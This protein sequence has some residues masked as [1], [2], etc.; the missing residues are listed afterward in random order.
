VDNKPDDPERIIANVAE[1]LAWCGPVTQH[2]G[3]QVADFSTRI[4]AYSRLGER[5]HFC[6]AVHPGSGIS[7]LADAPTFFREILEWVSIPTDK[8]RIVNAPVYARQLV[9]VPQQEQLQVGPS[10]DYLDLL[11]DNFYRKRIP[12]PRAKIYYIS[13]AGMPVHFA[14]ESFIE[15]VLGQS[16]VSVIRPESLSLNEQL[17]IL[18]GARMLLF[19]EGSALH[20]I[21]LLGRNVAEVHILNRR[22]GSSLARCSLNPRCGNV[23]YHNIGDLVH[24][25]NRVGNPC[26]EVGIAVPDITQLRNAITSTGLKIKGWSDDLFRRFVESDIS[27][28]YEREA[29]SPRANV[30][31]SMEMID[32]QLEALGRKLSPNSDR[33]SAA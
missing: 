4:A 8:V 20:G 2:F 24:G 31:G 33:A 12:Q 32:R 30:A 13:R 28:W 23:T 3:H 18:A 10:E 11:D 9:C 1:P 22:P 19:A 7:H 15:Y 16:G 26:P 14:G 29:S 6:F 5:F 27:T 17:R 21:Q 25:L